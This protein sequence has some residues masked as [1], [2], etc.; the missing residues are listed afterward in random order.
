LAGVKRIVQISALGAQSAATPYFASKRA[1][2]DAL[3]AS[4]VAHH[5]LRPALVYGPSGVSSRFFRVFAALPVHPLP[6]G[7][8]QLLR[9]IHVDELAQIVARL[10]MG[11]AQHQPMVD[12]VGATELE[13]RQMLT[14]Y[15][16]SMALPRALQIPIPAWAIDICAKLLDRVPRSMLT[17]DTWHMLQAGS[18]ADVAATTVALG[19]SPAGI[20]TFI[21]ADADVLRHEALGIWRSMLLRGAL[22]VTW[23]G[24]AICS[25][26][27]YPR[28]AS[29]ALLARLHLQGGVALAALYLASAFDL[30]FG[31]ATLLRPGRRLWAAQA[32]VVCAYSLIV[33]AALPEFL[34]HPFG[35][36]LKNVPII[37]MLIVLL[38]EEMRP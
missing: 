7:G 28:A 37:A 25:A 12:L 9:P 36:L 30:L 26:L 8:H 18:T 31:V 16:A 11:A 22:A 4:P 21:G 38:S 15:R 20:E 29:L 19:R 14:T 13:Y 1:A 17:R 34:A 35:P 5:V 32:G 33:A 23:I 6:A 2:D 24:T 3:L 27:I 10:A